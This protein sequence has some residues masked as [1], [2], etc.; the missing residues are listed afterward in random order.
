MF[1][2]FRSSNAINFI[3]ADVLT[4][5]VTVQYKNSDG[6]YTY[7][8]VSRRAILNLALNQNIS[9]GFWVNTNCFTNRVQLQPSFV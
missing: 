5:S 3:E 1:T 8:N 2:I 6:I 7:N 9:L 4:G